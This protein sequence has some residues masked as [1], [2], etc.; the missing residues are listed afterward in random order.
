M[1]AQIKEDIKAVAEYL[2]IKPA[3]L[4]KLIS[5]VERGCGGVADAHGKAGTQAGVC[6][7]WESAAYSMVMNG[8]YRPEAVFLHA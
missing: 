7:G 8:A 1:Q 3:Q 5:L 2:A 6:L 4:G